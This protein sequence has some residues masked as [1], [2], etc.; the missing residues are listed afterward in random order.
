[1]PDN[2]NWGLLQSQAAPTIEHAQPMAQ[3][4]PSP[5][6]PPNPDAGSNSLAQVGQQQ[7]ERQKLG[8]L[9]NE[10][11]RAQQ[12]QPGVL[13]GQS[14]QNQ[15][16][17]LT[18]QKSQMDL[19]AAQYAVQQRQER[20]A[21]FKNA[22]TQGGPEAGLDAVGQTMLK[23]GAVTDYQTF[24]DNRLKAR[25]LKDD[26]GA[27]EMANTVDMIHSTLED[28]KP[29]SPATKD[30]Q[31]GQI[32]PAQPPVTSLQNYTDRYAQIKQRW[33]GAPDPSTFKNDEAYQ[34]NFVRPVM[35]TANPMAQQVKSDQEAQVKSDMYQANKEVERQTKAVTDAVTKYGPK[36][37]QAQDAAEQ[38][39]A[40]Q[41]NRSRVSV[42][43]G[44]GAL[45][46]LSR[47]AANR[48][49]TQPSTLIQQHT[50]QGLPQQQAPAPNAAP[51]QGSPFTP[52]QIQAELARRQAAT[53]QQ[54]PQGQPQQGTP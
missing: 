17:S 33:P 8:L 26:I 12:L 36:S 21:S 50:P 5:M 48:F 6:A 54:A 52:Q 37:Q 16:Q 4:A 28:A 42:G 9:Q 20:A 3:A 30:P 24:E 40:A 53:Q 22:S 15:G 25:S 35:V 38:L 14:L 32:I 29:G 18:N 27:K 39:Q 31:T 45:G 43:G 11:A 1:M 41:L 19:Q 13:Q 2:I 34:Q 7:I 23:Q 47:T 10:D 51:Q 44:A 49:A 46:V